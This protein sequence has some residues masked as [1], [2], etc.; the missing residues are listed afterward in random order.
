MNVLDA[1]LDNISLHSINNVERWIF[2]YQRRVILEREL[3]QDTLK[4]KEIVEL[5]SDV[6]LMKYWLR[7]LL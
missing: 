5:I 2:V 3:G 4:I 6:G 7:S 1:P